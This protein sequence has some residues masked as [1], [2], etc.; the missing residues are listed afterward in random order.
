M[1]E[2]IVYHYIVVN[3]LIATIVSVVPIPNEKGN[4]AG[5]FMFERI[6]SLKKGVF[7]LPPH[8]SEIMSMSDDERL[9]KIFEKINIM[10][11]EYMTSEQACKK[12][13]GFILELSKEN[14]EEL[15]KDENFGRKYFDFLR[16]INLFYQEALINLYSILENLQGNTSISTRRLN[17]LSSQTKQIIDELYLKTQFNYLM[18]VLVV[19]DFDFSK[20]TAAALEKQKRIAEIKQR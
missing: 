8:H 15:A 2:K 17:E 11:S 10:S 20:N 5:G 19:L 12:K 7:C 3:N 13:G 14:M 6:N 9:H 1:C 18:A 4:Y 16:K